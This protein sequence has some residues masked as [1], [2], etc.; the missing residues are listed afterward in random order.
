MFRTI[1]VLCNNINLI[2][3]FREDLN[4]K[5]RMLKDKTVVVFNKSLAIINN[6]E[7]I[8]N[9]EIINNNKEIINKAKDINN[10]EIINSKVTINTILVV[11]PITVDRD[12]FKA[13]GHKQVVHDLEHNLND[14][15]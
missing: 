2:Q 5:D 3:I 12:E 8:N 15:R 13:A 7:I 14:F 1:I 9:R 10:T 11:F 4:L 6:K